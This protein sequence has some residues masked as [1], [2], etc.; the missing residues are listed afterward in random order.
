MIKR[1]IVNE[2]HGPSR[3]N[4]QRRRVITRGINDLWQA[5]LVEMGAF[6]K[7]ND[8]YRYLLTVIDT[9]SKYAW[10]EALKSKN[11]NDVSQAMERIFKSGHGTPRI[12]Q[13]VD[14]TEFFN[15][16]F[17]VLMKSYRINH[18]STFSKQASI[19]ERFNRTLK[20]L[21]WREFSF[22][23]KHKWID[24]YKQLIYKYNNRVHRTIKMSPSKVSSSN[25]KQI[26]QTSYNHLKVF[27]A[28]NFRSYQ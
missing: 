10:G 7:S 27:V 25:E 13:T 6:S 24:M 12:L 1:E 3:K 18:Y 14:G 15:S 19:V 20:E 8:R 9:F 2:L 4:F 5:D 16:K 17:K 28:S 22:N 21:M 11:A 26:L 23:G